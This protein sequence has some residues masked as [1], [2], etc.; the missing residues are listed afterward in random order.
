MS[1]TNYGVTTPVDMV[2]AIA[3]AN[4]QINKMKCNDP[5]LV[6]KFCGGETCLQWKS[7]HTLRQWPVPCKV[8]TTKC[9]QDSDCKNVM[10][11]PVCQA[12]DS[13]EKVC[14]FCPKDTDSGHCHVISEKTCLAHSTLPYTCDDNGCKW[15]DDKDKKKKKDTTYLE[16]RDVMC[17]DEN[18]CTRPGQKCVSGKCTCDNDNDCPGNA[19]CKSGMC[20]G[21]R[22]VMGNF[23]LR[24]WCENP[25]SRCTTDKD[26]NYPENCK[27]SSSSPGVTDVPPFM[28][29]KG[30]GKCYI[31]Q[32]YCERMGHDYNQDSCNTDADCDGGRICY[33]NPKDSSS[34]YCTGPDSECKI[35]T[36]EKAA[37]MFVGKT[38][39]Y[40][41]SG[42]LCEGYSKP[43]ESPQVKNS[44]L[45]LMR[46]FNNLPDTVVKVA[47]KKLMQSKK[48]TGRD[49]AGPGINLYLITWSSDSD[50]R[51]L[52]QS[53]FD[54]DEVK[55]VFPWLIEKKKGVKY[56]KLS[57]KDIGKNNSLKRIFLT[58]SSS[59]WVSKNIAEAFV[60]SS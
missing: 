11:A 21:K 37:E 16:W 44:L 6:K 29:D 51:P 45:D 48:V 43:S 33:A 58:L 31:T 25:S 46:Q 13:G 18:P 36:G 34:K 15:I 32:P 5:D 19:T 28:Y 38:L 24:Q 12:N 49:F 26:G 3:F 41:F 27:G 4:D 35:T 8:T 59:Q 20:E 42:R 2:N 17:D 55:K 60:M 39:F 53:G 57:K 9:N 54:A 56:I 10:G 47:D 50:I 1:D 52:V 14:S 7:D 30:N 23:L 22:C 40:I